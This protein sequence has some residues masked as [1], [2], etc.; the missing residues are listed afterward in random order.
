M[1]AWKKLDVQKYNSENAGTMLTWR[2]NENVESMLTSLTDCLIYAAQKAVPSRI[3][4]VKGPMKRVSPLVL[5]CL[6][7]E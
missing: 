6:K 1:F 3:V 2:Y 7:I 4:K 5:D